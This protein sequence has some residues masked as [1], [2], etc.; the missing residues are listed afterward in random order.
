MTTRAA[1]MHVELPPTVKAVRDG[2][3]LTTQG[4]AV[5]SALLAG[6]AAQLLSYFR[7]PGTYTNPPTP[8]GAI[9][10][11]LALCYCA[12]L[13]NIGATISAFIILDRLGS[14]ALL[15]A[16]ENPQH[17]AKFGGTEIQILKH[18]GPGPKWRLIIWHCIPSSHAKPIT[19]GT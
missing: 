12:L 9:D 18:Y 6:V 5:V 7:T 16:R 14:L 10:A 15:Y 19:D 2:W 8:Q 11:I 13:L 4:G 1:S 3:Q 17:S